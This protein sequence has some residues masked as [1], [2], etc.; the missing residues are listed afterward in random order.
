MVTK[1]KLFTVTQW[2]RPGKRGVETTRTNTASC[3]RRLSRCRDV[4][5]NYTARLRVQLLR[6]LTTT[7]IGLLGFKRV[8][9][10]QLLLISMD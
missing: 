7:M 4:S 5:N 9:D 3:R 6:R 10:V 8:F 2:K 1:L